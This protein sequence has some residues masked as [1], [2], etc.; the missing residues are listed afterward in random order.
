MLLDKVRR[1]NQVYRMF[2]PSDVVV[3]G[4]SGGPDSLALLDALHT[5]AP[6]LGISLHV[7]HLNHMLRGQDAVEDARFVADFAHRLGLPATIAA[8]DVPAL[9]AERG[10]SLED[11]ARQARYEFF[12]EIIEATHARGVAVGHTAD[13]QVETVVLHWLRGSGLSGLRGMRPITRLRVGTGVVARPLRVLRP[14][15]EAGRADVEA[16]C[17]EHGLQ[18]RRDASNVEA[19]FLRNRV[20]WEL[21]PALETYN[22]RFRQAVLR[23]ARSASDDEDYLRDQTMRA[24]D[25]VA[26]RFEGGIAVSLDGWRGLPPSLQARLLREAFAQ[27]VGDVAGLASVH[28]EAARQALATKPTGTVVTWP[29][30]VRLAIDY[31]EFRVTQEEPAPRRLP[32]KEQP[33]AIPGST[34]LPEA[35]QVVVARLQPTPCPW[36]R[37]DA[38][39]ADLDFDLTGPDLAVRRRRPGD[40]MIPL[41]LSSFKK[42]QDVLVDARVPRAARDLVPIVTNPRAV[43]WVAGLRLDD[44]FR[45]TSSTQRVLCLHLEEDYQEDS[46]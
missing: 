32:A 36:S 6:E 31:R 21:I 43:V 20:R 14:L 15:L 18:P 17:Q 29:R 35:G 3:V 37:D 38:R 26:T 30:G 45:V 34:P 7:A 41:G 10:L 16:Y 39:H 4:V 27:L 19:T 46:E 22:P 11:A 24:W 2:A 40:R 8:R 44:R 5:L 25:A 42:L 13:D 12:A 28:V 33:L 23:L 9:R 1:A